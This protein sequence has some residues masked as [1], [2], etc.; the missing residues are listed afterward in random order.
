MISQVWCLL[1]SDPI[2]GL[3]DIHLPGTIYGIYAYGAG[4]YV[5]FNSFNL[6]QK[7]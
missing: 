4:G 2:A 3:T 5:K 1:A 7:L 6:Y